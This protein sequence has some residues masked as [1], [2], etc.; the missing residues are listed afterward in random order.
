FAGIVTEPGQ[1]FDLGLRQGLLQLLLGLSRHNVAAAA[2]DVDD[3]RLDLTDE[4]PEVGRHKSF[5]NIRIALPD[6]A[7][8]SPAFRS[9]FDVSTQYFL[10]GSSIRGFQLRKQRL[11]RCPT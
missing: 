9:V 5:P 10:W 6:H 11:F 4:T 2:K 8:V 1:A 7:P 3:R